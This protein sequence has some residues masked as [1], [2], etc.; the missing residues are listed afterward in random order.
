MDLKHL[1]ALVFFFY[2][3]GITIIH[4]QSITGKVIDENGNSMDGT[5]YLTPMQDSTEILKLEVTDVQ[6]KFKF[7]ELEFGAYQVYFSIFG[8]TIKFPETAILSPTNPILELADFVIRNQALELEE[9]VL[10]EKKPLVEQRIDRTVVNV[11]AIISNQ[12]LTALDIFEKSPGLRVDENGGIYLKGRSGVTVYIDD[13]P[14]YLSGADLASY[15]SSLSGASLESIEIMT[16]P[17]ARYDAA[18]NG[19]VINIKTKRKNIIGF[20]VGLNLGLIQHQY[21]ETRNSLNFNFRKNKINVYGN[22]GYGIRNGF[23]NFYVDR[24]FLDDNG[25]TLTNFDQYSFIRRKG[26]QFT[27][28]IGADFYQSDNTTWGIVL[29]GISRHPNSTT[30]STIDFTDVFGVLDSTTTTKNSEY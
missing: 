22:F 2:L 16:N 3:A 13:K 1:T 21:T 6:G 24:S 23:V 19:G 4:A 28:T 5:V 7:E 8:T 12:G 20:N 10:I 11:E 9:F 14:T 26:Y 17:P 27:S 30:N 18:G 25:N 15:L 29:G